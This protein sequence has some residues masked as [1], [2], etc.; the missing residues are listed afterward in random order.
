MNDRKNK[1]L[2][3]SLIIC[4]VFLVI[5]KLK[6]VIVITRYQ[7]FY[8]ENVV[9]END[10]V[11]DEETAKSIAETVWL[12]VYGEEIKKQKPY[13][14]K[15]DAICKVWVVRGSLPEP[16]KEKIVSGGTAGII[17]QRNNGEIL[18]VW[19]ER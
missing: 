7:G 1:I 17:I 18:K 16:T 6:N 14:V 19:H 5:P 8:L 2:L 9:G 12:K 3:I 4:V 10:L 13:K 11:S 15:Y